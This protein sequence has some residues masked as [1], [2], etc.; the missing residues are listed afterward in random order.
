MEDQIHSTR[1]HYLAT[2]PTRVLVYSSLQELMATAHNFTQ[3]TDRLA[4]F[5]DS[6]GGSWDLKDTSAVGI[7]SYA[8]LSRLLSPLHNHEEVLL[9]SMFSLGMDAKHPAVALIPRKSYDLVLATSQLGLLPHLLQKRHAQ[10]SSIGNVGIPK[11]PMSKMMVPIRGTSAVETPPPK[12]KS[13]A[14]AATTQPP[15]QEAK[16]PEGGDANTK[17]SSGATTATATTTPV[18][19]SGTPCASYGLMEGT[20]ASKSIQPSNLSQGANTSLTEVRTLAGASP[21]AKFLMNG[22]PITPNQEAFYTVGQ[23]AEGCIISL[24]TAQT[25]T[26][27]EAQQQAAAAA[28][29]NMNQAQTT[30]NAIKAGFPPPAK[31]APLADMSVSIATGSKAATLTVVAN[32]STQAWYRMFLLNS[33]LRGRVYTP[34]GIQPAPKELFVA[35]FA[36]PVNYAVM[37]G[38]KLSVTK[39]QSNSAAT[40]SIQGVPVPEGNYKTKQDPVTVS[41][42]MFPRVKLWPKNVL[43]VNPEFT[44][45]IDAALKKPQADQPKALLKVFMDYGQVFPNSAVLGGKLYNTATTSSTEVTT[46]AMPTAA[47]Q[48]NVEQ[49]ANASSSAGSGTN[50]NAVG[51]DVLLVGD[52]TT[53]APSLSNP[54]FWRVIQY[55][56]MIDVT[57]LL[58]NEQ[59]TKLGKLAAT[60]NWEPDFERK[61]DEFKP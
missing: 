30:A 42:W 56:Q 33:F 16:E 27:Q 20:Q 40:A 26:A 5:H 25:P 31:A 37:D 45:A 53:W 23:V 44:N 49:K 61:W 47:P 18:T 22:S 4:R 3:V 58:T 35:T 12:A 8:D 17:P 2:A 7:L 6:I 60:P 39:H 51:G 55:G 57:S 34:T 21:Q 28:A 11:T 24:S 50:W 9:Q 52:P 19:S 10:N 14:P 54:D 32:L 13:K 59:A 41:Q 43:T 1:G 36:N 38:G 48:K 46:T 29:A 15:A